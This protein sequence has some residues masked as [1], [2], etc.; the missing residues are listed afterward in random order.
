MLQRYER[1]HVN[2][3]KLIHDAIITRDVLDF[4]TIHIFHVYN[5]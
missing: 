5:T 3:Y 1:H 2:Q 4:V